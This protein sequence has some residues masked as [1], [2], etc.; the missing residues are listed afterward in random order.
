VRRGCSGADDRLDQL[1]QT[2]HF[3]GVSHPLVVWIVRYVSVVIPSRDCAWLL[4]ALGR[5][6]GHIHS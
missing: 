3:A 4:L 5:S 2:G 6:S 1:A